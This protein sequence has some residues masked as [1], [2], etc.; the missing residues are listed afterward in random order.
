MV[1]KRGWS[2]EVLEKNSQHKKM[3]EMA[4]EKRKQKNQR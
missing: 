3:K 4:R 2:K 1:A